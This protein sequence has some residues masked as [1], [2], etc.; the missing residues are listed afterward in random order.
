MRSRPTVRVGIVSWNTAAL[1]DRCLRSLPAA[2]EGVASDIVVVDND[3]TDVSVLIAAA[4]SG[5][6]VIRNPANVGYARAMNQAL[7]GSNAEVLIALNPDTEPPPGSLATLVKRLLADAR[8]GL[9][10]PRLANTDGSLQHSAYR[11]PSPLISAAIGFVPRPLLRGGLGERLFLEGYASHSTGDVDW[12]I[13]AVHV[14]R[15]SAVED[16]AA[17]GAWPYSERWFMYVEDLD[18]CWRLAHGGWL[19]RLEADITVPHVGNAAGEQAWGA[20]REQRW[21]EATYDWYCGAHGRNAARRYALVNAVVVGGHLLMNRLLVHLD[22]RDAGRARA[23]VREASLRPSLP[24]HTS[25]LR[26]GPTQQAN[27][28]PGPSIGGPTTATHGSP[29]AALTTTAS[30]DGPRTPP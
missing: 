12:M 30:C 27:A 19:R 21:L 26:R 17:Y 1:L 23:R 14:F 6:T 8:V 4:H 25:V 9:V 13:G 2:L 16:V 29:D 11:F 10:S 7:T 24:V 3:S 28:C 15:A 18:L 22:P 5:V 20:G